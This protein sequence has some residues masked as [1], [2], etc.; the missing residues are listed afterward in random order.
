MQ[1]KLFSPKIIFITSIIILAAFSRLLPHPPNFTA[2]GA[3]AL[4]GGA[5]YNNKKLSLIV[6]LLAMFLSDTALEFINGTGF[7]KSITAVYLSFAIITFIGYAIRNNISAKTIVFSSIIS[8][9][10]FF[11]ITNL[12]VWYTSPDFTHDLKGL[13]NC[14]WVA[15][16]FYSND[17]FGSFFFNTVLGDLFFSGLLFG[18]YSFALRNYPSLVKS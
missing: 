18:V 6:P 15:I 3:I 4:F 9:V 17:I 14:Y 2:I 10:L 13:M 1:T 11:L 8:S 5:L 16:P 7:H 12:S